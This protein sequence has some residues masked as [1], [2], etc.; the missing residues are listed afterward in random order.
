MKRPRG[1]TIV[2]IAAVFLGLLNLS[3]GASLLSGKVRAEDFMAPMPD[4]GDMKD[5]FSRTLGVASVL[6]GLLW[7]L[8][9]AGLL[10]LK[11]WARKITRGIAVV[12]L[13]GGLVQMVGAFVGKD[14]GHFLGGAII[15]GCYYGAFWY[16]AQPGV[17]VAF[18]PPAPPAPPPPDPAT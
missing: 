7:I 8:L 15:G 5:S 11:D 1:V 10:W 12:G 14:A 2:A 9:C 18:G 4:L 6:F 13:L 16:L 3:L 17:K